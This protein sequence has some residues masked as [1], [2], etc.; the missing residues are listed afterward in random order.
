ML[1]IA[2]E[3]FLDS[4]LPCL[5]LGLLAWHLASRALLPS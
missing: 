4:R 5:G 2:L 1:I 3:P